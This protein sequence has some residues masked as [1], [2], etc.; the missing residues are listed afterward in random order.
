MKQSNGHDRVPEA[1]DVHFGGDDWAKQIN[2]D[3]L[4][5]DS[6]VMCV[7]GQLFGNYFDAPTSL[8]MYSDKY[9]FDIESGTPRVGQVS[10]EQLDEAWDNIIDQRIAGK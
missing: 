8:R 6:C 9:G 10:Y 2:T 1:L 5:M 4:M 3:E 7:L